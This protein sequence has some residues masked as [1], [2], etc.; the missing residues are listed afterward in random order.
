MKLG[1][2]T[3]PFFLGWRKRNRMP[4]GFRSM[5]QLGQAVFRRRQ[6]REL[7]ILTLELP[8]RVAMFFNTAP[9]EVDGKNYGEAS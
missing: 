7:I 1:L 8:F 2:D 3:E 5:L 9:N 6:Q 4:V